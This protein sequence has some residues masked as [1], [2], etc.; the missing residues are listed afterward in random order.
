MTF[1][2]FLPFPKVAYN[3]TMQIMQHSPLGLA[4]AFKDIIK[5][6]VDPSIIAKN[7]FFRANIAN[8]LAKGTQGTA[9]MLLGLILSAL[10]II[11]FDEDDQYNGIVL[12][13]GDLKFRLSDLAPAISPMLIAAAMSSGAKNEKDWFERV[14]SVI[15]DQTIMGT[16]DKLFG[17]GKNLWNLPITAL[18]TYALQYIP[19]IVKSAT[20]ILDNNYKSQKNIFDKLAANLPL[21]SYAVPNKVN[22]YT[23]EPLQR[24]STPIIAFLNMFSPIAMSTVN[25]TSIQIEAERLGV[26]TTGTTGSFKING[27]DYKL[28]G[29]D[30]ETFATN[31]A[32]YVEKLFSDFYNNKSKRKVLIENPDGKSTFEYL[33]YKD[34]SDDERANAIESL[35]TKASEL[36]KINYWTSSGHYFITT[37]YDELQELQKLKL[38]NLRYIPNYNKSKYIKK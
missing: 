4:M 33:Y 28:S 29:R 21:I 25:K 30:L 37:S 22:P 27:E 5:A 31:R 38:D 1:G 14:T 15:E 3:I 17:Y 12:R 6:K 13:L 7:P 9:L 2:A 10:K 16:F 11:S 19:S 20:K 26:T 32:K 8:L 34:M 35:Y 36:A 23:G 18:E 24:Y